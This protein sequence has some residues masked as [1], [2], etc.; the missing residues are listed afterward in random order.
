MDSRSI[1]S[2]ETTAKVAEIMKERDRF[3]R[4]LGIEMLT[5]KPGFCRARL[6]LGPHL[7]NGLGMPHGAAIFALADFAFAA[8]CNSYGRTTV[9]LSMDIHFLSSPNPDARLTADAAE[10]RTG[11]RTAL[12]RMSVIDDEGNLIAELH[13]MAY[14][15]KESLLERNSAPGTM[16]AA[17][18]RD[19]ED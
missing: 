17:H 14:R 16:E 15:K 11:Q 12:Y 1:N 9:A 18:Q 7:V 19:K 4:L 10:V 6:A 8:A 5:L 13:G 3:A 2:D